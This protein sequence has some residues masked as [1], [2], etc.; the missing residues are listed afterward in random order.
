MA[1]DA[2]FA[3]PAVGHPVAG[4]GRWA[5]AL[6]SRLY[7]DRRA[8]GVV[9]T[10]AA[11]GV[12]LVVSVV[13]ERAAA[14]RPWLQIGTTAVVTWAVLG[15]AGLAREGRAMADLL[16]VAEVDEVALADA[17]FRLRNL[18]ARDAATLLPKDL[19]RATV[20]SLA[21]NSS[22]AV[23][24]PLLWGAVAGVPGLVGYR[25]VNTLDA[26]VGYHSPR[27]EHFGWASARL[28]DLV[29]LIPARIAGAVTAGL[30]PMVGGSRRR[31][32]QTMVHDGGRHP[33][34][35][36]GWPEAAAAGAL[37]V[38]LGGRNAYHGQAEIRPE[39]GEGRSPETS[40]VRRAVSLTRAAGWAAAGIAAGTALA[41]GW[42]RVR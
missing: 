7:A 30:A 26:M 37:G 32:W 42:R 28:D 25:A 13:L 11:V 23:V 39:L 29:N 38:R 5:Q 2:L 9:F 33:S 17:R 20:E 40:D 3:D 22:D 1:A 14:R 4:F 41:L 21:E 8:A 24:A 6:E 10:T 27:Y 19:A 36:A 12:P 15:G 34:P 35:N 18:C 31:T 16:D